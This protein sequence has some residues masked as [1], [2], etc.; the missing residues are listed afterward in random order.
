MRHPTLHTLLALTLFLSPLGAA[1]EGGGLNQIAKN[2]NDLWANAQGVEEGAFTALSLSMLGWGLGLAAGIALL[3][4]ILQ[5]S[6]A[7][8]H[9]HAHN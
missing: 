1:C 2:S 8:S 4:S 3:A 7:V 9:A 5:Q 6:T